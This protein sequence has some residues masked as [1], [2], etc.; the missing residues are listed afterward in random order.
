MVMGNFLGAA[1]VAIINLI[2]VDIGAFK[3]VKKI[4]RT[5]LVLINIVLDLLIILFMSF[6]FK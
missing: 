3:T 2:L 1:I 4:S 5:Q 6:A